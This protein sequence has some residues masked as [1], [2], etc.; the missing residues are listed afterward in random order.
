MQQIKKRTATFADSRLGLEL[1]KIF[2][3]FYAVQN[4]INPTLNVTGAA[5]TVS[6]GNAIVA[7]VDGVLVSKASA[8]TIALNGPTIAN[9]GAI[10][11]AWLFTMDAA[12]ALFAY[13]GVPA[14]TLAGVQLPLIQ[15]HT[16]TAGS[17]GLNA[18]GTMGLK[19]VVI[20]GMFM[21]NAS[22][23]AFIPGTTL[24]NVANLGI[25][26]FGQVG[27]FFPTQLSDL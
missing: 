14:A 26:G 6:T 17:S 15:E 22:V 13:A 8:S 16:Y 23:G 7:V 11:Q 2:E 9:T 10:N 1:A 21:T 19:Q 20:G 27:P 3:T 4:L 12:G 18:G 24:L 25:I 5:A